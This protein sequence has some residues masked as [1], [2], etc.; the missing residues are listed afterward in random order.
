ME[1]S[2]Y[3][4]Q[5][6]KNFAS[7]NSNVVIHPGNTIMTMAEAK[8]VLGYTTVSESF[9]QTFG[10]YDLQEMLNVLG[11]VDK[12]RVRFE[13]NYVLIGD[14]TGRVEIKYFFSDTEMLTS[15][16]KPIEMPEPDVSFTLDQGTLNNL[17]RAAA[18]LG[19]NEV[20]ITFVDN[21]IRL[22]I[23]D[24]ENS[25]SNTYSIDVD[26]EC[27]LSECNFIINITNLKM[28][29]GDYKVDISTKLISQF[30]NTSE[31]LDLKYWVALEKSSTFKE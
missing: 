22:S 1:L 4:M 24:T 21:V 11:L 7:I 30:T 16:S 19:H 9:P 17:K 2:N 3:T 8:N 27:S 29:P 14:S 26:G 18:A 12:P 10:I 20:S 23:L 15:P 13:D 25:T 5:A 28:I 31:E 6:L